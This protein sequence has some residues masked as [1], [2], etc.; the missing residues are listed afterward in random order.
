M[1]F[2]MIIVRQGLT[3]N[4]N[5]RNIGRVSPPFTLLVRARSWRVDLPVHDN[6][7]QFHGA[8]NTSQ[9]QSEPQAPITTT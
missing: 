7:F 1:L 6:L 4:N 3:M 5:V 2:A 9:C 8:K